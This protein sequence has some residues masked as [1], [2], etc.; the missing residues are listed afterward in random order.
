MLDGLLLTDSDV[1]ALTWQ[2]QN[3]EHAHDVHGDW[4]LDRRIEGFLRHRGFT[5]VADD[6]DACNLLLLDRVMT[7]VGALPR[8]FGCHS[9]ARIQ[10]RQRSSEV[11]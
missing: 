10:T 4:P 11:T 9:K 5:R 1:D 6:D 2:F 8:D 7:Y 3:P